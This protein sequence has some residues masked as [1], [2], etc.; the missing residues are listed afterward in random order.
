[1]NLSKVMAVGLMAALMAGVNP[2]SAAL[3]VTNGG[4][5]TGDFTGWTQVGN[6][7]FTG[8]AAGIGN[9]NIHTGNFGA[10]FGPVGS[11]GGIVQTLT[12]IPSGTYL[13]DFWLRSDGGTPNSFKVS[14]DGNEILALTQVNAPTFPYTEYQATV[15]ATGASTSL[16][17]TFLQSPAFFRLD[18]VSVT[19]TDAAAVPEPASMVAWGMALVGCGIGAMRKRKV[20][21]SG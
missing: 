10:F 19:A 21:V 20:V 16:A 8:V 11:E 17:F 1:M 4:F 13:L 2:A 7:G 14:W 18:D 5:E 15:V 9:V 12:T 6:T 3:I